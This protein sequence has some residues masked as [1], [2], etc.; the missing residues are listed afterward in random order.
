LKKIT[1]SDNLILYLLF[2]KRTLEKTIHFAKVFIRTSFGAT[3]DRSKNMKHP[4]VIMI[5]LIHIEG[6]L[7]GEIQ[8]FSE[9]GISIGRHPASHVRFPANLAIISRK[10][11]DITRE[12]NRFKLV[13]HSTN[14]TFVNGKRVKEA[15]LKSGD[16]L[17]FSEGGPKV[18]FLTQMKTGEIV[19]ATPP[20][21][22][23]PKKP[24]V[25]VDQAPPVP[26]EPV[27]APQKPEE[28][29]KTSIRKTK[30]PLVVQYGPTLRT[31]KELPITIGKNPECD[32]M[33]EHASLFDR[34]A[35]IFFS[36][37]Y[38]WI[39]DLTGKSLVQINQHP[40]IL[41]APLRQDDL[42]ALSPQGPLFRFL[43]DGRLAEV[44]ETSFERPLHPHRKEMEEPQPEAPKKKISKEKG[45]SRVKKL[46][47][48]YI[49]K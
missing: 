33:L 4:P 44:L 15:Y 23:T 6:P 31:F 19:E 36:E 22:S 25:S 41:E 18:S 49:N 39:K 2:F 7:K 24:H 17:M 13:D 32:F 42:V 43:G 35:Q 10:H 26:P 46:L 47:Q 20:P 34:H 38:Y 12:G 45:M 27:I 8:E 48:Q 11:A 28:P 1:S 3:P 29:G 16:V 9:S 21:S 14:G 30:V 40:I 37:K 5:Q